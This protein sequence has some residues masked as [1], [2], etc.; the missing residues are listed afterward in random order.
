MPFP[1]LG[2]V[3]SWQTAGNDPVPVGRLS[4]VSSFTCGSD[5]IDI[6]TLGDTDGRRYMHGLRD[7]GE[8]TLTGFSDPADAG[9]SALFAAWRNGTC[10]TAAVCFADGD[11][12]SFQ[13]IVR[14]VSVGAATVDGAVAFE[15][16]LRVQG[17]VTF[18]QYD[19]MA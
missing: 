13:A 7:C 10:G 5:L 18:G 19:P 8:V 12:A 16:V 17:G 9:Q 2:T 14:S 1:G 3:F 15:A 4:A 11:T 6:T